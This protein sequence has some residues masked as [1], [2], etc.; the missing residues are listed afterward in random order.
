MNQVI[1]ERR[2]EGRFMTMCFATWHRSRRKLRIANAGQEQPM[3]ARKGRCEKIK[4]I[5]FPLGMYEDVSYDETTV[6]LEPGDMVI[7]HS[8]GFTDAQSHNGRFFGNDRICSLAAQNAGLSPDALA[9]LLI[10][11]VD[12]FSG[13]A[14][15]SDDRTLVI[16]KVQ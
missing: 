4:L 9:D 8:D 3:V 12:K 7:F 1:G 5:G 11:E 15:P 2:I 6:I 16:L 10:A 13:G 14:S